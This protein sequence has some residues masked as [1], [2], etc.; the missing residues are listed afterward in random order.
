MHSIG[1]QILLTVASFLV[2]STHSFAEKYS[3][4]GIFTLEVSDAFE[5]QNNSSVQ[6]TTIGELTI[7]RGERIVFQQKGLNA[8][9]EWAYDTYARIIIITG[10]GGEEGTFPACNQ[11]I[12]LSESDKADFL[13]IA[14]EDA[15]PWRITQ[16]PSIFNSEVNGHPCLKLVYSREGEHGGTSV[17]SYWFFNDTQF[18]RLLI[19]YAIPDADVFKQPLAEVVESFSWNNPRFATESSTMS[20]QEAEQLGN[21]IIKGIEGLIV[22][23]I[24]L[25]FGISGIVKAVKR[26]KKNEPKTETGNVLKELVKNSGDKLPPPLPANAKKT[27]TVPPPATDENEVSISEAEKSATVASVT[28]IEEGP[29]VE[30]LKRVNYSL[31]VRI[32]TNGLADLI[33]KKPVA[34]LLAGKIDALSISLNSSNPEIYEKTV[35]PVFKEK[36]FPAMLAFAEQAKNYVPKVVLTTVETTITKEDEE[37]CTRLCERLGVTHRIRKFVS[38]N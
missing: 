27:S 30:S 12:E 38:V 8:G 2:M 13:D 5:L 16:G 29:Q 11:D 36:A 20:D 33:N 18:A 4:N 7:L 14:R 37:E 1:K 31:P 17:Q 19:S 26:K 32:N 21:A 22:L 34:P 25:G 6:K 35:R 23:C 15:K 3:V 24:I 9:Y 28:T 10:A